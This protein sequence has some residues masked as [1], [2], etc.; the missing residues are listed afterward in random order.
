MKPVAVAD[1]CAR[2]TFPVFATVTV[3]VTL[4][5]TAAYVVGVTVVETSTR[6]VRSTVTPA[7]EALERTVAPVWLR[8][9]PKAV[10]L[11]LPASRSAWVITYVEVQ[12]PV[13]PGDSV[14]SSWQTRFGGAPRPLNITASGATSETV[15]LPVLVTSAVKVITWPTRETVCGST[16][17][18][19]SSA[20]RSV[21]SMSTAEAGASTTAPVG[22]VPRAAT[23]PV[24]PPASR[25]AWTATE[26]AVQTISSP[27]ASTVVAGQVAAGGSPAP[28]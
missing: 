6:G 2:V 24:N 21:A 26:L 12:T 14:R 22:L 16:R 3:N 17:R 5:P 20:G 1:G 10:A 25:S 4:S 27:G 15:T 19:R 13:S 18:A 9:T 28:V 23:E 8:P 11:T 7:L